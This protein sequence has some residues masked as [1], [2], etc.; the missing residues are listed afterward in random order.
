M[1]FDAVNFSKSKCLTSSGR[2]LGRKI[3]DKLLLCQHEVCDYERKLK[4][5][6][7]DHF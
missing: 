4:T 6:I 1:I 5:D 3:S 7:F 2:L